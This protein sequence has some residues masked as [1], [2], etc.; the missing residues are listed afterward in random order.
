LDYEA[1]GLIPTADWKRRR[2][3]IGWQLGE[4]LSVA[5]GQSYN[6]VTPL[7]MMTLISGI[8][9]GGIRHQPLIIGKVETAEGEIVSEN[10]RKVTGKLPACQRTLDIVRKGLWDAVNKRKGTAWIAAH[11][12]DVD[13]SGK[14][15]T[16]QLVGRKGGSDSAYKDKIH[17]F[18]HFKPHAWFAAYA[19]SREPQIAVVVIVEHGEHGSSAAAPLAK[20]LIKTYSALRASD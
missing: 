10:N 12:D 7:Q 11:I 9:N 6:L 4:T 2:T 1:K 15:G 5:I 19:P 14:T 3:G 8:A 16:A 17:K 20:E 18:D 13:I